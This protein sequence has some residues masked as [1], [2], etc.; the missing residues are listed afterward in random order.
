[1]L[2]GCSKTEATYPRC[3]VTDG[4]VPRRRREQFEAGIRVGREFG[5]GVLLRSLD[6]NH[7]GL[8]TRT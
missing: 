4:F 2:A 7:I 3:S 1:M 5:A 6:R 8:Q